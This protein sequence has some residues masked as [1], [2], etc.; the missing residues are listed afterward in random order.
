MLFGKASVRMCSSLPEADPGPEL[1][2]LGW[3]RAAGMAV[4]NVR[5]GQK[6]GGGRKGGPLGGLVW[7]T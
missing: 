3:P 2:S 7:V 5:G 1:V 4:G 6:D